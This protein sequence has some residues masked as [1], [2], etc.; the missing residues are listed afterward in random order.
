MIEIIQA[1]GTREQAVIAAMRQRAAEQNSEIERAVRAV[2]E[3]VRARGLEAVRECS[4]RFDGREPYEITREQMEAA[5]AAC[6]PELIR[7][8]EHAAA[9]IRDY[10]EKLLHRSVEWALS[11]IHI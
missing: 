9:N 7:A 3:D 2:M 11:L 1:D 8:M 5:Y 10:N 4:L 6:P